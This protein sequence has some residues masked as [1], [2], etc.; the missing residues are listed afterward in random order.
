MQLCTF[1]LHKAQ[2][3]MANRALPIVLLTEQPRPTVCMGQRFTL[4]S[5]ELLSTTCLNRTVAAQTLALRTGPAGRCSSH[6]FWQDPTELCS[7]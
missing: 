2:C 6:E 5:S 1:A 7:Q 3:R 4:A